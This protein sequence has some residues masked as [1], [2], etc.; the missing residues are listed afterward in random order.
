MSKLRDLLSKLPY[1]FSF[2]NKKTD[3]VYFLK[4]VLIFLYFPNIIVIT[5]MKK[6]TDIRKTWHSFFRTAHI[7]AS[8]K[9]T[10]RNIVSF[11]LKY[12]FSSPSTSLLMFS[13]GYKAYT[14]AS[15][16]NRAINENSIGIWTYLTINR[17]PENVRHDNM[18]QERNLSKCSPP[19]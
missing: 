4:P 16:I 11:F 15:K 7:I 14:A 19:A 5:I 6:V 3:F 13:T 18:K 9:S 17:I 2:C 12:L 10:A 8:N 1:P